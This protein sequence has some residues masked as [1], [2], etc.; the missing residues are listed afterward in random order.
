MTRF[1]MCS[2]DYFGIEYE[3]NPWMRLSN[4][5]DPVGARAQWQELHH[6]L[7]GSLGAAVELMEPVKGLPDLVFTANAGYVEGDL[8]VSSA[9]KHRERQGET[10][11]FD[12]WFQSHG[13]RVRKLGPGCIFEGMGDA[14]PLG[15]TVFAGYRHRSEVCSH[16][17][18]GE[19][20]RRRVLSLELADPYFYHLD[21]CFCPLDGS[22]ALYFPGAFDSYANQAVREAVPDLLVV[23]EASAHRFACNAVVVGQTV[24]T[25]TGC[26]DLKHPLAAR[27]YELRMV[28]LSE[29]MKSG[30]SAKCLTL[31]LA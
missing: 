3:I 1:L 17:A 9:F 12:S 10:P 14:L 7:T 4:Q 27:G 6:V 13:Y 21:T 29:F 8:F 19:I 2:P 16:G 15:D 30:G 31:R 24:V 18:L 23:S 28:D 5:S 11:Y 22:S 25:N 20:I 26:D